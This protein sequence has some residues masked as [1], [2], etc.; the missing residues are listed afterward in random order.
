[1]SIGTVRERLYA[2]EVA[3]PV[4]P[5]GGGLN[6]GDGGLD[7]EGELERA[8]PETH[9]EAAEGGEDVEEDFFDGGVH[10]GCAA[11]FAAGLDGVCLA[12]E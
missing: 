5:Q 6:E 10:Y 9:D 12:N 11:L 8:G 3:D 2:E 4:L 7:E 1:M